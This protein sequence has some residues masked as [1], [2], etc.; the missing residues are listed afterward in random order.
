[1]S[2]YAPGG[3]GDRPAVPP[4][5]DRSL[6]SKRPRMPRSDA[7]ALS[8]I[9]GVAHQPTEDIEYIPWCCRVDLLWIKGAPPA[10]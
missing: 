9:T 1:M 5:H 4:E 8:Q 2:S 6:S 10:R 3:Y 7:L